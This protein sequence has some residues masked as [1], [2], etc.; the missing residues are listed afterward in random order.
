MKSTAPSLT[1]ATA[2]SRL[3][4]PEM[5]STG[6][7]GSRRFISCSNC[8]PSR[9][10]SFSHTSSSTIDGRLSSMDCS[11]PLLSAAERTA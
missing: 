8:S 10:E 9:R 7:V 5:R 1:A 6:M 2:V 3:P 4:W 11:A